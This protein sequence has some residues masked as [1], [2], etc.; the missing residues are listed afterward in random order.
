MKKTAII[1]DSSTGLTKQ[2]ASAFGW[3]FLP[4]KVELD[5]VNYQ[6]GVDLTQDDLFK[7]FSLKTKSYK[8]ACTPIGYAE[9]LVEELSS[10]YDEIIIFPISKH[11]SSQYANL[12][13]LEASYPKLKVFKSEYI[14]VLLTVKVLKFQKLIESGIETEQALK[15]IATWPENLKVSLF[16][17]YNDYLVKGGRLSPAAATLAKLFRIVPIIRFYKGVL[18]KEG[19]GRVFV[20][21]I[22]NNI[23]EKLADLKSNKLLILNNDCSDYPTILNFIKTNYPQLEVYKYTLPN[24]ISIHTGPEALVVISIPEDWSDQEL[25]ILEKC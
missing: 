13:P 20:K 15:Q 21:T 2:Q 12:K 16:P 18:E 23:V 24:A 17:K 4:L 19:K 22:Q 14:A 1:V 7:L 3:Y 11:L 8:T 10:Q 25:S 9:K 5:G 6:D